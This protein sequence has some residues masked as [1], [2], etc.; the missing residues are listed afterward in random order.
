MDVKGDSGEVSDRNEEQVVG[1]LK[2]HYPYYKVAMNFVH[3]VLVFC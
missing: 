2:E 3:C 1:K